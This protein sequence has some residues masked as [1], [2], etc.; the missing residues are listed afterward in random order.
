MTGD[1]LIVRLM[2]LSPDE[3]AFDVFSECDYGIVNN[4]S[5]QPDH[6]ERPAIVLEP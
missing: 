6:F 3:L 1:E 2:Q 5:V 4:V